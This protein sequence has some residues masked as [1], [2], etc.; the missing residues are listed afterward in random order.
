M[1]NAEHLIKEL[2]F[3]AVRSS[4]SGGQHV[5]KTSTKVELSFDLNTS[6]ELSEAQKNRLQK[7]L[8]NRLTNDSVL[9]LQ[10]GESR[11]Q[12]R[13]KNLVIVRFL[14]LIKSN[15]TTPKPRKPT[16]APKSAIRKRLKNK[17]YQSQKKENRKPPQAD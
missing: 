12:Y 7:K 10:C 1:F 4:G 17:R 2:T 6:K 16:K 5:N 9:I 13:N 3:K 8:K 14:N 15:L 11:S